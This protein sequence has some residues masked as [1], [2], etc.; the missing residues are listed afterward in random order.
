MTELLI[1]ILCTTQ[2]GGL[3]TPMPFGFS[4]KTCSLHDSLA[5]WSSL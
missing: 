2:I 5:R 3:V 4:I 1:A